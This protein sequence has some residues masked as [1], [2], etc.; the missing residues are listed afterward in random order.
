MRR[1][2]E[3]P[4]GVTATTIRTERTSHAVLVAEAE[5][6]RGV[7]VLVPGWTGS[8]EDFA[9]ILPLLAARGF[10]AVAID[11]RG[12]HESPG[13]DDASAY[14]LDALAADLVSLTESV[15]HRGIPVHLVGHSFGGLVAR[16]AVRAAV[17][18]GSD[19]FASMTLM[20]AGPGAVPP[21]KGEL[22]TSLADSVR[23]DGLATSWERLLAH[24]REAAG[25]PRQSPEI[26][27]FLQRRFR[28]N[29]PVSLEHISRILA[30]AVDDI[31][32]TSEA[33]AKAD[34]PVLV[35]YGADDNRWPVAEQ[36]AMAHRLGV[37]AVVVNGA[38][39][40]PA[41]ERPDVAAGVLAD[42]CAAVSS[43]SPP[44]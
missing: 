6:A 36:E 42:F 44:T 34:I 24:E 39:H 7:V 2:I 13:I 9:A 21:A 28:A 23:E 3:L 18:D 12:Q 8:K 32:A 38:A 26:E 17:A 4:P 11:Q 25:V 14:T 30:S 1:I 5:A 19:V 41:V 43:T 40:S 37:G 10:R 29:H 35:V 33:V 31:D 20:C 22:L 16:A 27:A 15:A